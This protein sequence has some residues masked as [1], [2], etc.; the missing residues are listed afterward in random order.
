MQKTIRFMIIM[1]VL[2]SIWFTASASEQPSIKIM[3]RTTNVVDADSNIVFD[4]ILENN[5]DI[6]GI[7]FDIEYDEQNLQYVNGEA[8]GGFASSN[9]SNSQ[10]G[11]IK[12][13]AINAS[14]INNGTL[15]SLTFKAKGTD[16]LIEKTS[17][18]IIDLIAGDNN[19][20]EIECSSYGLD[21][22]IKNESVI[23]YN[24]KTYTYDGTEKTI[25]LSGELPD[26]VSVI[27]ANNSKTN[28]GVYNSTATIS[29][30][31]D[32]VIID[33]IVLN[34]ILTINKADQASPDI[35]EIGIDYI[36]ETI[37]FGSDLEANSEQDFS[38]SEVLS[39]DIITPNTNIYIS[40]KEKANYK[41][42]IPLTFLVPS[43]PLAPE[44]PTLQSAA[45]TEITLDTIAGAEYKCNDGVWQTSP[46]FTD[47]L[48]KQTYTFYARIK[49]TN[50]NFKS[51]I[52]SASSFMTAHQLLSIIDVVVNEQN[53]T[54][55]ATVENNTGIAVSSAIAVLTLY[56]D[57]KKVVEIAS[58]NINDLANGSSRPLEFVYTTIKSMLTYKLFVWEDYL[59]MEPIS[60]VYSGNI[61]NTTELLSIR[62]VV[63]NV[64]SKT[65]TATIENNTGETVLSAIGLL[66][67]YNDENKVIDVVKLNI[68]NVNNNAAIT[69]DFKYNT[70]DNVTKYKILI[71][72]SILTMRPLSDY[73]GG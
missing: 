67:L 73:Y 41:R 12:F 31:Y 7:E 48:P 51:D 18:T 66:S 24:N 25:I 27:Y 32:Y 5:T 40:Y 11:V 47:L 15:I 71:W 42:S 3:P 23:A 29:F 8:T 72:D 22:A 17:L 46:V 63:V 70:T 2:C 6:Y 44:A 14:P 19:A 38:G 1:G 10:A 9:L 21:I 52:S 60:E 34:S 35:S 39:N 64:Q 58:L 56:D 45:T 16:T 4:F 30:N 37:T 54:I 20:I 69:L 68:N 28:A 62:D 49:A 50:E 55:S 61:N 57:N 36:N 65:I 53:K 26:G 43:R 13:N 59:C 33:P